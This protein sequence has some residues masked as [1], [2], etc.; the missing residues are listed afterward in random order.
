M[1]LDDIR[2]FWGWHRAAAQQRLAQNLKGV[3]RLLGETRVA[4]MAE[5][6]EAAVMGNAD[7]IRRQTL[8]CDALERLSAGFAILAHP[9]ATGSVQRP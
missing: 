5:A 6:W 9:L 1:E 4:Q 2:R 7:S 8:V 3:L